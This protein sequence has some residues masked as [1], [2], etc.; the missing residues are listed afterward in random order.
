MGEDAPELPVPS[1]LECPRSCTGRTPGLTWGLDKRLLKKQTNK[2][3]NIT[4]FEG[5][6]V[7]FSLEICNLKLKFQQNKSAA[8]TND[9]ALSRTVLTFSFQACPML[10]KSLM[11]AY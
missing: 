3:I 9:F 5:F 4:Y 10:Q 1:A 7:K 2:K 8:L 6:S 11:T